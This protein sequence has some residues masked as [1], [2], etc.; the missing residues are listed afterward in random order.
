MLT[1]DR[2]RMELPAA[3]RGREGEIARLVAE[4]LAAVSPAIDRE[5]HRLAL[6]PV[7]VHPR[8]TDRDVARTIAQAV[9]AG[10][11]DEP[12]FGS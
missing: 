3:F 6:A 2:L 12:R 11:R 10:I 4:E 1:I 9:H 8:A 5:I 7:E